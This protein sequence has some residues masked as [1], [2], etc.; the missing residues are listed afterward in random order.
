MHQK[1]CGISNKE[2]LKCA[3]YRETTGQPMI[4]RYVMVLGW[5]DQAE[6]LERWGK[7]F[8]DYKSVELVELLPYHTFGVHK[9]KQ[10]GLKYKLM[11]TKPPTKQSVKNVEQILKK[12]FPNV[13]VK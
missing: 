1:L 11:D 8:T 7:T 4:L 13:V 12:Y 5:N 10:L 3:Q 6:Y 2:T 9:F